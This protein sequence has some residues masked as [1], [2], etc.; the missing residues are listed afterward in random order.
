MRLLTF[1]REPYSLLI[2]AGTPWYRLTGYPKFLLSSSLTSQLPGFEQVFG[3]LQ[4][5]SFSFTGRD[6]SAVRMR[7]Y[8]PFV[9]S[10][11][12]NRLCAR[13]RIQASRSSG[14]SCI[15]AVPRKRTH[16]KTTDSLA[17]GFGS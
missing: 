17:I 9:F 1:E 14:V 7:V 12:N 4:R 3:F 10:T 2:S 13:S 16:R 5:R 11:L 6:T 8:R 15:L